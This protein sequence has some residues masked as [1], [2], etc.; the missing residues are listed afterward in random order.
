MYNKNKILGLF[1]KGLLIIGIA[2]ILNGCTSLQTS[3]NNLRADVEKLKKDIIVL[4]RQHAQLSRRVNE[5][6]DPGIA[7]RRQQVG[8]REVKF[9][10][11]PRLGNKKAK[12]AIVEF[13][14]FECPYCKR[15]HSKTF[16]QIKQKYIDSGK[17]L[18]IYRDFPLGSHKNA[19]SAAVAANCAGQQGAYW[20]VLH[21]LFMKAPRL[22]KDTYLEIARDAKLDLSRFKT[23]LDDK[24]QLEEVK[25]DYIYG[26][27]LGIRATPTFYIGKTDGNRIISV[28]RITGAQPFSVFEQYIDRALR[29]VVKTKKKARK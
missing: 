6:G 5:I 18:Y 4:R 19:Q 26:T 21:Q 12:V 16:G 11:D 17:L 15:F 25:Q 20:H 9:D 27:K 7:R 29:S 22:N 14:D 13:S 23:C 8:T 2:V 28:F 1:S 24:K 3:D 10:D